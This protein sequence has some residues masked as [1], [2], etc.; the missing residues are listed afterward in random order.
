MAAPPQLR[1]GF[2]D[3]LDWLQRLRG[4]LGDY[5]YE[6]TGVVLLAIA[7]ITIL[8]LV[9]LS[10]GAWLNPWISLSRRWLG[11]G[12]ILVVF[13]FGLVGWRLVQRRRP[14]LSLAPSRLIALEVAAFTALGVLSLLNG[15][16]L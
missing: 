10:G 16:S 1:R 3:R 12:A 13:G 14:H 4:S 11:W 2:L 8:G 6:I 5:A 15:Q 7:F 9:G